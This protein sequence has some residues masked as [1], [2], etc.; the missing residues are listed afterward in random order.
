MT[1]IPHPCL[2]VQLSEQPEPAVPCWFAETVILTS[3]LRQQGL[4]DTLN[5]QVHLV[6][7]RFGQY[8]VL[9]LSLPP[10]RLRAQRG[11]DLA[12]VL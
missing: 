5:R 1:T 2:E 9:D 8:E 4:L 10:L 6:R 12:S 11:T 7:A 3:Y